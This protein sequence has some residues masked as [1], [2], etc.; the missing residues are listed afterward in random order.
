MVLYFVS[1]G[2]S[3]MCQKNDVAWHMAM[4][5]LN[6]CLI[7]IKHG[8]LQF[9]PYYSSNMWRKKYLNGEK[10]RRFL[11]QAMRKID[12]LGTDNASLKKAIEELQAQAN[13]KKDSREHE[14]AATSS[15]EMEISAMKFEISW[16][17]QKVIT[18]AQSQAL[19]DGRK[20]L[21]V[22]EGMLLSMLLAEP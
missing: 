14:L 21:Y 12:E 7:L 8:H 11:K 17:K 1:V 15:L 9:G 2:C 10:G 3:S 22:K 18:D 20:T 6:P 19:P 16:L 13:M 5:L 4:I